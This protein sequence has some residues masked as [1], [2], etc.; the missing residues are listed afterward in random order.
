MMVHSLNNTLYARDVEII[1]FERERRR[2][3]IYFN[4]SRY[5]GAVPIF[6]LGSESH[7]SY[8]VMSAAIYVKNCVFLLVQRWEKG[9]LHANRMFSPSHVDLKASSLS[10]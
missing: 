7:F 6:S 10:S 8:S 5:F 3:F 1:F 9:L 2:I 4:Y